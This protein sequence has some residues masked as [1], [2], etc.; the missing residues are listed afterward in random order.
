MQYFFQ[1]EAIIMLNDHTC[2]F[3]ELHHVQDKRIL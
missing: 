2:S 3:D 1:V